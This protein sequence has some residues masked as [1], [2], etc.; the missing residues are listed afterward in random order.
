MSGG[1]PGA[2]L[3]AC[4]H[5]RQPLVDGDDGVRL[6][7]R[8]DRATEIHPAPRLPATDEDSGALTLRETG[9]SETVALL[10]NA[11]L[12]ADTATDNIE[13]P[14]AYYANRAEGHRQI[15]RYE[16]RRQIGRG[17]MGV[18]Y[19]AWDPE[20]KKSVA[21]KVL[22]H[23]GPASR[24]QLARFSRETASMRK[25][26]H[27]GI[28][29]VLDSG[30]HDSTPFYVMPLVE[31]CDLAELLR[32]AGPLPEQRAA[33]LLREIVSALEH[34]HR[35][36]II[37]RDV[38]PQNILV[39]HSDGQPSL[40][41][42]GLAQD[43][44]DSTL[45]RTGAVLGT[46][47]YMSP[48]QVRGQSHHVDERTDVYG[49]GVVLYELLTGSPPFRGKTRDEIRER[50]REGVCDPPRRLNPTI[51]RDIEAICLRAFAK[52]PDA[53]YPQ[54]SDLRT[55]LDRFLHGGSVE[56][57][58]SVWQELV[59]KARRPRLRA[60]AALLGLVVLLVL[61]AVRE[62]RALAGRELQTKLERA[63]RALAEG[64]SVA[65]A[66]ERNRIELLAPE[67]PAL[68]ALAGGPGLWRD[69]LERGCSAAES[70]LVA[71]TARLDPLAGQFFEASQLVGV[72]RYAVEREL[73]HELEHA[74][75]SWAHL[76]A[77]LARLETGAPDSLRPQLQ[78]LRLQAVHRLWLGMNLTDDPGQVVFD[79]QLQNEPL[80]ALGAA[81]L[82]GRAPGVL[83]LEL[84]EGAYAQLHRIPSKMHPPLLC[85]ARGEEIEEVLWEPQRAAPREV[86]AEQEELFAG[87]QDAHRAGARE[88][89]RTLAV[90][91]ENLCVGYVD[92][93]SQRHL[94]RSL[95]AQLELDGPASQEEPFETVASAGLAV[96]T[97]DKDDGL[98]VI[99]RV[100]GVLLGETIDDGSPS[101][102]M[103][104]S[105]RAGQELR[106]IDEQGTLHDLRFD[107]DQHHVYSSGFTH[108]ELSFEADASARL[109][110]DSYSLL[111]G[112]YVLIAELA[113]SPPLQVPFL[114][115]S[116]EELKLRL[117]ASMWRDT[118]EGFIYLAAGTGLA[119]GLNFR[120]GPPR[121]LPEAWRMELPALRIS[122]APLDLWDFEICLEEGGT[123]HQAFFCN[124]E[125]VHR[126]IPP[127]QEL[128][129]GE[130]WLSDEA[131]RDYCRW[132][133]EQHPRLRFRRATTA[134]IRRAR[135]GP[136][137]SADQPMLASPYGEYFGR[138]ENQALFA[139]D[140][141]LHHPPWVVDVR[142]VWLVAEER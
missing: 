75:E 32:R 96:P 137:H 55:D 93:G 36:G 29:P 73:R 79:E 120:F 128:S 5:C 65:A 61:V 13:D 2:E 16:L 10:L 83:R 78:Q 24:K 106:L 98:Y 80:Q 94:L 123:S 9:E 142:K 57:R 54:M 30:W 104:R 135:A 40:V 105:L 11:P 48:E 121:V 17:G 71:L 49:V 8:C 125:A 59:Q 19:E 21:L 33:R 81:Q 34:A 50:V 41:D 72:E 91:L 127:G 133:A 14:V 60:R 107:P 70:L 77:Q 136:D 15:G 74:V 26:S 117:D 85:N 115:P 114:L 37:H 87:Y 132:L 3:S 12:A 112:S 52:D 27:P 1:N 139:E 124:P 86:A 102:V 53:R 82:P 126:R 63:W 46:P 68:Q 25:L 58:P 99:V 108:N 89:A 66:A 76:E 45:T 7:P 69:E 103:T 141:H 84:P 138:I 97:L 119:A 23:S 129:V 62:W 140:H 6:C 134:E 113:G 42:F 101:A 20:K 39:R 100:D 67:H 130:A 43:A 18:V 64:D 90:Q 109:S 28:V 56:A 4:P 110:S 51:S 122:E 44:E 88:R 116:G 111:P 47:A 92:P 22:R 35:M 38:K 118:P 131:L 31:G 95:L